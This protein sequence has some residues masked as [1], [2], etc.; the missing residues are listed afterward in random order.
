MSED[1]S[2]ITQK[3]LK[4]IPESDGTAEVPWNPWLAVGFVV[5]IYFVSQ[6]VAAVA[7][8]FWPDLHHW[9]RLQARNWLNNAV[10]AQF[11]YVLIAE[12]IVM[13]SIYQFMKLFGR[14]WKSIGFRRPRWSDLGMGLLV[15]PLYYVSYIVLE[16][17]A[18]KLVPSLNVKQTQQLGFSPV[19]TGELILTFISL[20]VLPPLVEETLMRGYL[21]TS[22]KKGL[23]QIAA[24]LVTSV[25]FA[26]AHLQFGSGAP[27]L[28]V[29]A[30]DT[31]V[32][33]LFLIWLREKTGSLWASM[34]LHATKNGLAFLFLFIFHFT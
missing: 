13:L 26:C 21:Y 6:I 29:A 23:P 12:A 17:I 32:L 2:E 5:A 10:S 1:S 27:L 14:G 25:I 33:S 3:R 31:F 30:I 16:A 18:Q 15:A 22:L 9:S 24:A 20:V 19:G 4:P 11:S 28:W 34:T 7:V 8:A